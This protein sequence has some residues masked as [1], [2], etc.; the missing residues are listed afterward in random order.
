MKQPNDGKPKAKLEKREL[1]DYLFQTIF[2]AVAL[3]I[4]PVIFLCGG[5]HWVLEFFRK[6]SR[7]F[8]MK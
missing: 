1:H 3:I 7:T 8:P 4:V 2:M 5:I 6:H